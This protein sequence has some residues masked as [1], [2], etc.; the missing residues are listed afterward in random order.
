MID[1]AREGVVVECAAVLLKQARMPRPRRL[2][3]FRIAAIDIIESRWTVWQ[4]RQPFVPPAWPRS[5][6]VQPKPMAAE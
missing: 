5:K 3:Q 6:L 4:R 2:E 1:R